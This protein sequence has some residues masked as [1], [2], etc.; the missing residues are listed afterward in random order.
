M[1]PKVEITECDSSWLA[2]VVRRLR[3]M[4]IGLGGKCE[5]GRLNLGF[6]IGSLRN[7]G[8]QWIYFA[9]PI[10]APHTKATTTFVESQLTQRDFLGVSCVLVVPL[11]QSPR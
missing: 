4:L 6:D 9:S 1:W 3:I 2:Y 10:A 7:R 8:M 11:S 5:T